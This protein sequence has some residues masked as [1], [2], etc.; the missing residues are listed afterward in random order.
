MS[1]GPLRAPGPGLAALWVAQFFSQFGDSVFQLAFIWLILD[2]TG[3]KSATGIAATISYLPSL[4]FG[5]GAGLL[6]DRWNRRLIMVGADAARAALLLLCSF[7]YV[8]GALTPPLLTAIAFGVATAAVLFYPSRDAMLPDLV[9]SDGLNRANAFVQ[10]SQQGAL[11]AGPMVAG[12]LIQRFGVG[13]AF[14]TGGV[15][16]VASLGALLFLRGAG[17]GPRPGPAEIGLAKDFRSGIRAIA[18]DRALV[19]LLALTA[20]D[21]LF[22]MGPAIVGTAV[23]VRDTLHADASAYAMVE[24]TYGVSMILSSLTLGRLGTRVGCGRLLLIGITAD[25]LTYVPLLWC[26]SL[27]YLIGASFVHA[28]AIPMIL[29]P[30]A[31]LVQSMVTPR[32]RGRV[33]AL[34]NMVVLGTTAVSSGLA[35]IALDHMDAPALFGWIG[36]LAGATG[37]LGFASGRLRRL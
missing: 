26:R 37:L 29:I 11:F 15:F 32:L 3:S 5:V 36:C 20:L 18:S 25:G 12:W 35:G 14:P 6:V 33:F 24:A 10:L 34:V 31:T 27:P 4:V 28:L 1:A 19:L 21:N 17:A 13:S 7:L 9:S 23:L 22:L 2:L 8:A 16:F 30:R